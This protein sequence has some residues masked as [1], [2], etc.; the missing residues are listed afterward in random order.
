[1][2]IANAYFRR[3]RVE[4]FCQDLKRVFGL[5]RARV[6]MFKRLEN[7]V[8]PCALAYACLAHFL[9][10][11]GDTATRLEKAMKENLG[12]INR[13]FRSY[14]ANLRQLLPLDTIR[15]IGGRPQ[16]RQ[17]SDLPPSSPAGTS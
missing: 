11:C 7:L 8:A 2:L 3:W 13:A 4:V 9:P 10:T 1:M 14:V 6:R 17:P 15:F 12:A 16:K 5:E